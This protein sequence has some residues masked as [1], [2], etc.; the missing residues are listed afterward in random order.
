MDRHGL[1]ALIA[2]TP[3]NV[4]Y[5][6]DFQS[7]FLFDVPWVACA[8]LPRDSAIAPCLIVNEIEIALLVEEPTWMPEVHTYY[9]ELYDGILPVHTLGDPSTYHED[10][11][12]IAQMVQTLSTRGTRSVMGAISEVLAQSG[13]SK[14]R[15]GFDDTRMAAMLGG[16]V[17]PSHVVDASNALLEIRMIKTVD[18]IAIMRE[19]ARRNERAFHRAVDAIKEGA[20]WQAVYTEYEIGVVQEQARPLEPTTERAGRVRVAAGPNGTTRSRWATWC[21]STAC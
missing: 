1:D 17:D 6:S 9:F 20:T 10:D 2:C 7:D 14:A 13:L 16:L 8:I 19:G 15:L 4:C 11:A 3:N 18:E 12:R 5:L 21:A